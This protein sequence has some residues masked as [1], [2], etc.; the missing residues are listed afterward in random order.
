MDEIS[1]RFAEL[2]QQYGPQVIEAA[3]QAV[4]VE[5][6][7]TLFSSIIKLCLAAAFAGIGLRLIKMFPEFDDD[8]L[9]PPR[10]VGFSFLAI[11]LIPLIMGVW[12]WIDPWTWVAMNHPELWLAKQILHI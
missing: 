4:V 11:S 5:A 2:A 3:K 10:F 1:K 7:S 8:W 9:L 12:N 6:Y